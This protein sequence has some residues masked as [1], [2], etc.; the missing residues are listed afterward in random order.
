ME[1]KTKQVRVVYFEGCPNHEPIVDLVQSVADALKIPVNIEH[2]KVETE[3]DARREKLLG[4]PTVLVNGEDLEPDARMRS[5]YAMSCRVYNG[6]NGL[7]DRA[8]VAAALQ[9]NACE[10]SPT[11]AHKANTSQGGCCA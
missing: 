10:V 8:M 6:P 2:V 7:P 3:A 5:N 9:G 1:T 11:E 4:S